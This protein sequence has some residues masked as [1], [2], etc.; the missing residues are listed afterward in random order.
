MTE[1]MLMHHP[2]NMLMHAMP[3][4]GSRQSLLD[5]FDDDVTL[6]VDITASDF[7][8]V[9]EMMFVPSLTACL[10]LGED[11]FKTPCFDWN[12]HL[13]R[14]LL[15]TM[16]TPPLPR[17]SLYLAPQC[18]RSNKQGIAQHPG[19]IVSCFVSKRPYAVRE[20]SSGHQPN[21]ELHPPTKILSVSLL[22][23]G[24]A[25]V[26]LPRSNLPTVSARYRDSRCADPL[27]S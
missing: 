19:Y 20:A 17:C 7:A 22:S 9:T 1:L 25:F 8:A 10:A 3:G 23:I 6:N 21:S 4:D 27:R 14:K 12:L 2:H 18:R 11:S 13:R 16:Y 5:P 15:T 24:V 26:E